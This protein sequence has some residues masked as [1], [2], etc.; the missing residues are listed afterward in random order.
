MYVCTSTSP[1][2]LCTCVPLLGRH[3]IKVAAGDNHSLALTANSQVYSWGSNSCGQLGQP[4]SVQ[5]PTRIKFTKGFMAWDICAGAD[6]SVF[7][8]DAADLSPDVLY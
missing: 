1:L 6:H 5:V 2:I 3:V 8:G 4:D 7:L